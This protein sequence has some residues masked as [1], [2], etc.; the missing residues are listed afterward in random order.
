MWLK[1]SSV[2]RPHP[3]ITICPPSSDAWNEVVRRVR[4]QDSGDGEAGPLAR[5]AVPAG[6]EAIVDSLAARAAS[7]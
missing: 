1:F 7:P 3:G 5:V 6:G 4:G 2:Y